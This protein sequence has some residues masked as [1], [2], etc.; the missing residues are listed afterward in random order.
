MTADLYDFDGTVFDGESGTEFFLFCLKRHPKL[1]KYLLRQTIAALKYFF[2]KEKKLDVFKTEFYS[3]LS[4]IDAQKESELF[5]EKNA[6]RM[7]PWFR[8]KESDVPVVICS[9]SPLF[10]IKPICD[11]LGVSLVIATDLDEKT[12][13]MRD[14]NC[15]GEGKLEY[16]K[17]YA[18]DYT[19][20]DVY[21]DSIEHDAP[22]LS[23][24]TRDKYHVVNGKLNKI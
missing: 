23:L 3:F 18:P 24:A 19:F 22:I 4:A 21:T 8:P 20:R 9:A 10:Q 1:I 13:K 16:I 5:W 7:N 14:I 17:K 11:R 2:E 15:K 6:H 12:G